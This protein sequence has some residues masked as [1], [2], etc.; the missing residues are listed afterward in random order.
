[1]GWHRSV[2]RMKTLL[3]SERSSKYKTC[4]YVICKA[5]TAQCRPQCWVKLHPSLGCCIV[6]FADN[7]SMFY[8]SSHSRLMQRMKV[9]VQCPMQ[10]LEFRVVPDKKVLQVGFSEL[11]FVTCRPDIPTYQAVGVS[12]AVLKWWTAPIIRKKWK[13][14]RIKPLCALSG[15][16]KLIYDEFHPYSPV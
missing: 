5:D 6:C 11:M 15:T 13:M 1:M 14:L 7:V 3:Y 12:I 8:H 10:C 2:I 9:S 4:T 16:H